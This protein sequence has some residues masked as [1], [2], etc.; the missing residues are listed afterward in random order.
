MNN[1]VQSVPPLR[2]IWRF[3]IGI[4]LVLMAY[5]AVAQQESKVLRSGWYQWDPYQYEIVKNELKHLTGL[6][7]QLLRTV[8]GKMGIELQID[9]VSWRQH[10]QDV[11]DGTRDIAG[12]AYRNKEREA[13]AYYSIPYR[14]EKTCS[15]CERASNKGLCSRR[16][17]S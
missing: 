13:Y 2:Q 14:S 1:H 8:F 4:L 16:Q 9:P 7:V 17:R 15:T 10:L 11:K 3:L 12:G 6:D 5:S